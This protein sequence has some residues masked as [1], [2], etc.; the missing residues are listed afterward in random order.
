MSA[1]ERQSHS[2]DWET[3]KKQ[4]S[5]PLAHPTN[6]PVRSLVTPVSLLAS[7]VHYYMRTSPGNV[8]FHNMPYITVHYP[9][10]IPQEIIARKLSHRDYPMEDIPQR[11]SHR[12]L[13]R[14][15]YP[16]EVKA[17][18]ISHRG[19]PAEAIPQSTDPDPKAH[20]PTVSNE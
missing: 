16:M 18:R 4:Q 11:L 15:G 17:Q 3:T 13:T 5:G 1:S 12:R 19:Y 7:P 10:H 14:G 8:I 2:L 6:Q 20:Y 9:N